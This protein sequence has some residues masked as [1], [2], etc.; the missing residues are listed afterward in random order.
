LAIGRDGD[1][2]FVA[3]SSHLYRYDLADDTTPPTVTAKVRPPDPPIGTPRL[4]TLS[5]ADAGTGVR[6][7]Q[8]RVDGGTWI[9]YSRP[10]IVAG[11][12]THTVDYRAVDKVFNATPTESVSFTVG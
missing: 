10:F 6:T 8:Y 5:A 12:G 7:V 11:T 1:L 3:T 9:R 2:Y 4:V